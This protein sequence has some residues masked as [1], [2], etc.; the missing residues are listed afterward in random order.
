MDSS[1]QAAGA[2]SSDHVIVA[3]ACDNVEAEM[4]KEEE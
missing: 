4:K 1:S 2:S 3:T